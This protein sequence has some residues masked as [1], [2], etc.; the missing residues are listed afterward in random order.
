MEINSESENILFNKVTSNVKSETNPLLLLATMVP[1]NSTS[2]KQAETKTE[3]KAEGIKTLNLNVGIQ[4]EF[5]PDNGFNQLQKIPTYSFNGI[6]KN[7][8]EQVKCPNNDNQNS[9]SPYKNYI[10]II[11]GL[12]VLILIGIVLY[13]VL[14][15]IGVSTDPSLLEFKT[16]VTKLPDPHL[17]V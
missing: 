12:C 16:H 3:T 8:E 9:E 5:N 2:L 4:S 15:Y 1:N 6:P 7:N 14:K 10:I 13:F 17:E 11:L